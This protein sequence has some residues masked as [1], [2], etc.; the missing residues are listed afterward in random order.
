M[1]VPVQP[2]STL[3]ESA[4]ERLW[5]ALVVKPRH[6]KSVARALRAKQ[7]EE[8][9]PLYRE[10]RAWSDRVKAV[11]LPLFCG[12]VFCYFSYAE[13]LRVL[14]TPG[15]VCILGAGEI[16][17]PIAESEIETIRLIAQSG[18]PAKPYPYLEAGEIVRVEEGPLAGIKGTVI[19]SKG[20]TSVIISV[21]LL[22][23]SVAVEL[24]SEAVRAVAQKIP[25][26][27]RCVAPAVL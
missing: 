16:F 11:E 19:R 3:R 25:V 14:N 7:L 18:L 24:N 12:Y 5:F 23:R 10:R 6:E 8:F 27:N 20:T 4:P 15:V 13:R 17:R 21:E 1:I 9:L 26:A 22:K 2:S